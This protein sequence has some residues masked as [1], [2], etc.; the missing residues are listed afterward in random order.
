M[1]PSTLFQK[2]REYC[3]NTY[4]EWYILS[5][6]HGLLD[7]DGPPI[8]PY[9]ET[10]TNASIATRRAWA[11]DIVDEFG[12]RGFLRNDVHFFVHA[13]KAYYGELCPLL[14]DESVTVSLPIEGL[15]IGE[16]L[17]WYNDRC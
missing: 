14:E 3:E 16:T 7:P 17:A 10:L 5:A 15:M 6:K 4:D 12:D 9:D 13:G 8:E 1:T 11:E 2:A